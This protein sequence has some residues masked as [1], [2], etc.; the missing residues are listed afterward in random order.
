MHFAT[1]YFETDFV[2]LVFSNMLTLLVQKKSNCDL[3]LEV[4]RRLIC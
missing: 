1:V 3:L 2:E 4:I